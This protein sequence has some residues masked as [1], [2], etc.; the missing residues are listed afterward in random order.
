MIAFPLTVAGQSLAG[1]RW[2]AP[3]PATVLVVI[4]GYGEYAQRHERLIHAA[5]EAGVEVWACDL[6]GHG[7]SPGVRGAVK[8]LD[9]LVATARTLVQ[10]AH[11]AHPRAEIVLFGHSLGGL[12]ALHTA[13]R[14]PEHISRVALSAPATVPKSMGS[15]LLVALA[16]LIVKLL[17][18]VGVVP[19]D[20]A[21]I[22]A[23]KKQ[24]KI[25]NEDENIYRG[26]VRASAGWAIYNG[27]LQARQQIGNLRLPTLIIHGDSDPL[28][29]HEGSEALAEKQPLITLD[30]VQGGRHEL[31]HESEE[32]GIPAYFVQTMLQFITTGQHETP[33]T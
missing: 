1:Y 31:Y 28:A 5:H 8:N 20:P 18:N 29:A 6:Y 23:S 27:G 14:H 3:N 17:P 26:K 24:Q 9:Q 22:S 30:T 12:T 25:Y 15:P 33:G 19:L 10:L 32:S 11:E 21:G 2:P 7:M 4:H 13:L 16:P